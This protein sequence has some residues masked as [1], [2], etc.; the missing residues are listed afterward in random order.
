MQAALFVSIERNDRVHQ[1][2]I[3]RPWNHEPHPQI[4]TKVLKNRRASAVRP[5]AGGYSY[6][7]AATGSIFIAARA[8]ISVAASATTPST[9]ATPK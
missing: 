7:S 3:L 6:R 9:T 2:S 5:T 4:T 1:V 8:G